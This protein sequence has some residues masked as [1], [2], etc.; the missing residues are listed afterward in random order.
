MFC[1]RI[2]LRIFCF[3][4]FEGIIFCFKHLKR[5]ILS[6]EVSLVRLSSVHLF[7]RSFVGLH[8]CLLIVVCLV[9]GFLMIIKWFLTGKRNVRTKWNELNREQAIRLRGLGLVSS[10]LTL[11]EM[12]G[13][14]F[15]GQAI[16]GNK[17]HVF[18]SQLLVASQLECKATW[19]L[20]VWTKL[21]T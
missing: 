18:I 7:V 5:T 17:Y 21:K 9:Q 15:M 20:V 4:I 2:V 12:T 6:F 14:L 8:F 16:C 3:E 13:C 11:V 19:K 10:A 1:F